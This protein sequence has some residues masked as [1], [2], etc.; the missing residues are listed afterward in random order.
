MWTFSLF[1]FFFVREGRCAYGVPNVAVL[2][3]HMN[4]IIWICVRIAHGHNP[5]LMPLKRGHAKITCSVDTSASALLEQT[6][7]SSCP[8]FR[9]YC[10]K[11]PG[12]ERICVQCK[13]TSPCR[14][15]TYTDSS[16]TSRWVYLAFLKLFHLHCS[17]TIDVT[18]VDFRIP[19]VSRGSL[20][21]WWQWTSYPLW[22]R[23]RRVTN[24]ASAYCTAFQ[25]SS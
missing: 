7:N 22:H 1:C 17:L 9:R 15:P 14:R 23:F 10:P 6:E 2:A 19:L 3:H 16:R 24:L 21:W 4:K 12:H 20:L 25:G 5:I 18:L 11:Q 8:Y 13:L